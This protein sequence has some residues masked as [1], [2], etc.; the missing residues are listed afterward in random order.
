MSASVQAQFIHYLQTEL[1]IPAESINLVLRQQEQPSSHPH[2][3]MWQYGLITL[4]QLNTIFD[5]LET[6]SE[7]PVAPSS[8]LASQP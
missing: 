1:S 6:V 2:I 7:Q 5:W 8:K 4:G 3:L